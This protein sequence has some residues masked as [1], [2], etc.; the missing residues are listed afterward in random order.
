MLAAPKQ[1]TEMAEAHA[2]G[3]RPRAV[4]ATPP[5]GPRNVEAVLSIGQM[6]YVAFR[7]RA[8]GV[9]PLPWRL[10]QRIAVAHQAALAAAEAL[11]LAPTDGATLARYY[12][13]LSRVPPLLWQACRPV[14]W[15]WRA[16]AFLRLHRNPFREATEAELIGLTHFFL[17]RRMRSPDLSLPMGHPLRRK[18]ASMT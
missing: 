1:V 15:W 12:D 4:P 16:L 9:P 7:G 14:G 13:A 8:Y 3:R 10:G 6:E 2:R 17:S 5:A 11:R 18:T